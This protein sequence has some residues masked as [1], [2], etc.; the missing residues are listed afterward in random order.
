MRVKV[1][2]SFKLVATLKG[3]E[4]GLDAELDNSGREM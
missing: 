1:P 3:R 2:Y 4:A